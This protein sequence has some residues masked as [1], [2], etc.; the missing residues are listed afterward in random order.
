MMKDDKLVIGGHTFDS[1][2]ILGSGKYSMKLI[3]AAVQEIIARQLGIP[4]SKVYGVVTFYSF[5]TTAW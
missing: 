3:E 1:R 5:F 4:V 2:F